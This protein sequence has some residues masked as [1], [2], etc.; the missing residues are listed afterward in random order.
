MSTQNNDYNLYISNTNNYP[1][2]NLK[3][4]KGE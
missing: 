2:L 1:L 3:F 4:H